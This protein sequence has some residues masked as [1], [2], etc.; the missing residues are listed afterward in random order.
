M[1]SYGAILTEPKPRMKTRPFANI[2]CAI[3][4]DIGGRLAVAPAER[5]IEI[6]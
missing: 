1:I 4:A 3:L 5:A 6:V 2:L